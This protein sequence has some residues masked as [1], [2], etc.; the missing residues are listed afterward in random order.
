MRDIGFGGVI[1]GRE[2]AP[3]GILE[4]RVARYAVEGEDG[5]DCFGTILISY[6]SL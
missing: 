4:G 2:H 1:N 6:N 3:S 5:L